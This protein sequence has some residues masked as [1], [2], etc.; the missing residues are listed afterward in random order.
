MSWIISLLLAGV[1]FTSESDLATKS[2]YSQ[3][4]TNVKQVIKLDETEHLEQSYPLNANGRV[5]VSNINGS[6]VVEAWDRNEVKLEAVK[7]ADSR[8]TLSEVELQIDAR[9]ESFSVET[10]YSDWKNR[11]GQRWKDKKLRVDFHLMVPRGANL[12]EIESV[13][14][15]IT[16]SNFTNYTKASAVNG[17]VKAMNLRGTAILSTVNGTTEADFDGVQPSSKISL[18]TVN[19]SVN[20]LVPSDVNATVKADTVNGSINN[21]FGLPI[22]K[23]EYVGRDLYGKIGSGE[24]QIKLESVNGG[25]SIRRKADG[26]TPN[27]AINLLPAKGKDIDEDF[28]D[29]NNS[30]NDKDSDNNNT[31]VNTKK[32]NRDISKAMKETSKANAK[33]MKDAQREMQKIKPELEKIKIEPLIVSTEE[34]KEAI[35]VIDTKELQEKIKEAQLQQKEALIK[36][37]NISW[38]SPM[39]EEKTESFPVKSTPTVTIDARNCS[40]LVRGWDKPEVKYSVR[41]MARRNAE[42]KTVEVKADKSDSAVKI[43]VL[44][45]TDED[46][47]A[48]NFNDSVRV[49]VFVPKKSNLRILTNKEI[50][51]EGVSG[52]IKLTGGEGSINVRD[53]DGKL[54]VSA[55]EGRIRLIG[56]NGDVEAQTDCG[57]M[58]LDGDFRKLSAKTAQ[59]TIVLYLPEDANK[60]IE[61]NIDEIQAEGVSL[62]S[63]GEGKNTSKW[64]IGKGGDNFQLFTSA[65]GKIFIRSTGNLT[66]E[67]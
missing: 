11:D 60:I 28:D 36:L 64:K 31:G 8:E 26:R 55:S 52:D 42:Q 56:F 22:R 19:G 62:Q 3:N 4:N 34:L 20:L 15:S 53:S 1:M 5:S 14:G 37:K 67:E 6:I 43:N 54:N 33:A 39:M 25:L 32:M 10:D 17:G 27:P 21:D 66:A 2:N 65:E 40:V 7:T 35:K 61:S 29:D 50:R 9:P 48:F 12:N 46:G 44:N 59:G 30:G 41:Q 13:N 24:A 57:M 47:D 23:G 18:S 63:L 45:N 38:A 58:D 16:L 49:E 51:L